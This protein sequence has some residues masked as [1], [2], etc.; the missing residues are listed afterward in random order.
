MSN[1]DLSLMEVYV[2]NWSAF[3]SVWIFVYL[4]KFSFELEFILAFFI[5]LQQA[6]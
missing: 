2:P 1:L 6:N 3:L 4:T 5:F